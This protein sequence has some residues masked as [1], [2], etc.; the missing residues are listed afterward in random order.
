MAQVL[1]RA[2]SVARPHDKCRIRGIESSR[3]NDATFAAATDTRCSLAPSMASLGWL[4]GLELTSTQFGMLYS[5]ASLLMVVIGVPIGLVCDTMAWSTVVLLAASLSL[6]STALTAFAATWSDLLLAYYAM[7]LGRAIFGY[8][9]RG[10]ATAAETLTHRCELW[11]AG[12]NDRAAS[13][14]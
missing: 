13:H 14:G 7:L 11:T 2:G 8:D 6:V 3:A 9:R 12:S 4:Q 1:R 10:I 5:M